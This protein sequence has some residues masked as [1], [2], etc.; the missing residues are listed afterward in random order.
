MT[1]IRPAVWILLLLSLCCALRVWAGPPFVTDDPEPVELHHWEFYAASEVTHDHS[2]SSGTLP[3]FEVNYGAI[4]NVQIHAIFPIAFVRPNG[5]QRE[6]GLGDIELGLKYRIVQEGVNRPMMGLFPLLELPTGNSDRGLGSG[7]LQAFFPMW[8]QKSWGAWTSYG[9]G[10]YFL[11]SGS[12]NRD[13]WLGGWEIQRDFGESLT[14]GGELFGT[15]AQTEGENSVLNFNVGGQVNF[16]QKHHLLF[17]VGR[18]FS[19]GTDLTAYLAYQ[20]T[21]GSSGDK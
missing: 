6:S 11:H 8:L 17:S 21:V 3:H 9:G 19:Q 12:G 1:S 20:L 2:G 5:G 10:G 15:T 13:Y 16:G 7:Q 14:L 4:P 18:S